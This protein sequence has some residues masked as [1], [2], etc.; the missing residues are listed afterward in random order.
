ME[1]AVTKSSTNLYDLSPQEFEQL[2]ARYLQTEGLSNVDIV[3][4]QDDQGVDISATKDGKPVVAQVKHTRKVSPKSVREE[5]ARI[6]AGAYE[7][8]EIVYATSAEVPTAIRNEIEQPI[9]G[10]QIRLIDGEE[11]LAAI[12]QKPQI[13]S[14]TIAK[15]ANRKW[16]QD[17]NLIFGLLG[18]FIS[19]I[20]FAVDASSEMGSL[21]RDAPLNERIETVEN[22]IGNLKDL[23]QQ[24]TDIKTD[25]EETRRA[26]AAIEADYEKAKQ[27]EKLTDDQL[28]SIKLALTSQAWWQTILNYVFGF[29]LGVASSLVASVIYARWQLRRA[30]NQ[31][32]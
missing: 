32:T 20:A 21:F 7:P 19:V 4:G 13:G 15:A 22:A 24:L 8:T 25:M 6:L 9:K 29:I 23:E 26:K 3:G 11:I 14:T 10:V 2:V 31:S 18:V 5:I 27:L 16:W 30:I 28:N 17:A 12:R 1:W